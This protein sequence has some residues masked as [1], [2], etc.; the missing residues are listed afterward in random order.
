MKILWANVG[1]CVGRLK[2]LEPILSKSVG[3]G[4]LMVVGG[5]YELSTGEV[6]ILG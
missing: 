4:E 1:R 5:V 6:E 2:E 3:A